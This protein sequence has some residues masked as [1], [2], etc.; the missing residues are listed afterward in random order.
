M[1]R[2]KTFAD[3]DRARAFLDRLATSHTADLMLMM[4]LVTTDGDGLDALAA[5]PPEAT[6]AYMRFREWMGP[7]IVQ[8]MLSVVGTVLQASIV[9]DDGGVRIDE[10]GAQA[11][12][13][14]DERATLAGRL[15]WLLTEIPSLQDAYG[16]L[17]EHEIDEAYDL[18]AE[19]D[20][21]DL[22]STAGWARARAVWPRLE[23]FY[24]WAQPGARISRGD[25]DAIAE[26]RATLE[27]WSAKIDEQEAEIRRRREMVAGSV[28]VEDADDLRATIE[29]CNAQ[30]AILSAEASSADRA[31]KTIQHRI[32][33]CS[34]RLTE[35][36][37][38]AGELGV[39]V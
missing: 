21:L 7:R 32:S 8:S 9:D 15:G 25:A 29:E 37:V 36:Y 38:Q 5:M 26:A 1:I 22:G 20:T 18:C 3:Q 35:L 12:K 6:E 17:Y 4:D 33:E 10:A 24:K 11:I 2:V 16:Q 31:R 28:P 13:A 30:L 14:Q 23:E 19:A 34:E 27:G 39:D